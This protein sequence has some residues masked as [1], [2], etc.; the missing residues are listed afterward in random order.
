MGFRLRAGLSFCLVAGKPI[1]LDTIE[2][3]YFSLSASSEQS[4]LAL[5][6][7]DRGPAILEGV[8]RLAND[9]LLEH[10]SG[11]ARPLPCLSPPVARASLLD[12]PRP[13]LDP[14]ALATAGIE[15]AWVTAMLRRGRL[16]ALI[17]GVKRRKA[18]LVSTNPQSGRAMRV[19]AAAF[20]RTRYWSSPHDRCLAR[21]IAIAR[22]LIAT[23]C[24]PDLIIAVQVQPFRAHCWV[25]HQGLLVNDRFDTVE[26]F[27]PILVV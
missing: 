14:L 3:R 15:L 1:F 4:F 6:A 23:G 16:H 25:Q 2:D 20:A 19:A 5:I 11:D 12:A 17:E 24:G 21:S 7:G 22:R 13:P 27:T 10:T 9:R 26:P 8:A 18:R